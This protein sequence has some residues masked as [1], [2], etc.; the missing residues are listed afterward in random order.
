MITF[1]LSGVAWSAALEGGWPQDCPRGAAALRVAPV[2]PAGFGYRYAVTMERAD[3]LDLAAYLQGLAEVWACMTAEERGSKDPP[4]PIFKAAD[5]IRI[6]AA[7]EA[8][9]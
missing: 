7:V 1:N 5:A 6:R 2:K 9:R 8:S 4:E 3:A